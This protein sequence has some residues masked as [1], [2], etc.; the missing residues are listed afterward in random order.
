M[1]YDAFPSRECP[2]GTLSCQDIE[3]G[4]VTLDVVCSGCITN[5]YGPCMNRV[6]RTCYVKTMA[7]SRIPE[8]PA[9]SIPCSPS[10]TRSPSKTSD[11]P[12]L[13]STI[14]KPNVSISTLNHAITYCTGSTYVSTNTNV[15]RM[16]QIWIQMWIT[17]L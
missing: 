5:T 10:L 17:K 15:A 1:C 8:C 14:S 4:I 6:N 9:G 12:T 13:E 11:P 16:T 2:S 7:S 3:N